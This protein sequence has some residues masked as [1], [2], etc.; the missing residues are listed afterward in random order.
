[1]LSCPN[2]VIPYIASAR[3][4]TLLGFNVHVGYRTHRDI[5][6]LGE[7]HWL[8]DEDTI[9]F[10]AFPTLGDGATCSYAS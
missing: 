4:A 9:Q 8:M 7:I 2:H 6:A 3:S 1:M 5:S 10:T